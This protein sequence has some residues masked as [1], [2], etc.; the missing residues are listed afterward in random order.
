MGT[1]HGKLLT[2]KPEH[3]APSSDSSDLCGRATVSQYRCS[4]SWPALIGPRHDSYSTL[5]GQNSPGLR[6]VS[7]SLLSVVPSK[8]GQESPVD[9]TSRHWENDFP[10][11]WLQPRESTRN[12]CCY[13]PKDN[14]VLF[15]CTIFLNT[16]LIRHNVLLQKIVLPQNEWN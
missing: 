3:V 12:Y 9:I 2:V 4:G 6:H 14:V 1:R 15:S 10:R 16:I 8:A 11:L 13:S 7:F 5:I